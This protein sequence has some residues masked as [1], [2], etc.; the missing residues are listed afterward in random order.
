MFFQTKKTARHFLLLICLLGLLVFSCKPKGGIVYSDNH[1]EP[2]PKVTI[3]HY[4][5]PQLRAGQNPEKALGLAISGGGSR[6][7]YFSLGVL[8]G[9]DHMQLSERTF[10][11]EVDYV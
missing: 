7:E 10:L 11:E 9:L 3:E 1:Y 2:L 4:K 5:T 8:I 6:A